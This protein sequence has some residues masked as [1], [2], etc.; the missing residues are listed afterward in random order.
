MNEELIIDESNFAEYFRD[1]RISKPER[2]DIM[3]RYAAI[4]EF[5]E[6]QMKTDI[7]DLL[8]R[9]DDKVIA[10][11]QV[12]RKLGCATQKDAIR[13]CKEICEDVVSGLSIE[14]VLKKPYKYTIE[15]FYYTKR[16]YIPRD[17]PHW[18]TIG[19]ENLDDFLDQAGNKL[20]M[21]TKIVR[22]DD[23]NEKK[24]TEVCDDTNE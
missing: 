23:V 10:A 1:C 4:A 18:S 12:M 17:D 6:G 7:V 15:M 24:K 2:G 16:E 11:T 8:N 21:K 19:I 5:V 22:R 20:E 14:E 9:C 3:A 13:I